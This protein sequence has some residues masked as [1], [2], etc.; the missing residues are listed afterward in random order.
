MLF[1]TNKEKG[2]CGLAFAIMYYVSKGYTVSIP[3]NDTQDY[4]LV[5]D[6]EGRLTKVQVKATSQRSPYGYT[7]ARVASTGGTKGIKYKTVKDTD[8]DYLFV[9][10]ELEEMYEVPITDIN[11]DNTINFGPDRQ[12][13]RVDNLSTTYMKKTSIKE[14]TDEEKHKYCKDCGAEISSKNTS[15]YCFSCAMKHRQ[16]VERPS[17]IQLAQEIIESGFVGTGNK[18]GVSD[19]TIRK[20]C[21]AYQLPTKKEE[22]KEWLQNHS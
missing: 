11:T 13:Y 18:H 9:L 22:L 2:N 17:A 21:I 15:G 8:I 19:N 1:D 20:W 3:L 14:S 5:V 4:D 10:T 12:K 16:K 7:V 6:R